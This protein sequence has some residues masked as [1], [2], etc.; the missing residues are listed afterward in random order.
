MKVYACNKLHYNFTFRYAQLCAHLL[1]N[2]A[3]HGWITAHHGIKEKEEESAEVDD[4]VDA[5]T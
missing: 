4:N 1:V 3:H 2:A 5:S